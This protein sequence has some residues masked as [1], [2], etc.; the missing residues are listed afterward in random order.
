MRSVILALS[1]STLLC[2]S[3]A[4]SQSR[5][6]I[7]PQRIC[8]NN[9][10]GAI[11]TKSKCSASETTLSGQVLQELRGVSVGPKGD[12]GDSGLSG[13]VDPNKCY[14]RESSSVGSGY[15]AVSSACLVS[16]MLL[17]SGCHANNVGVVVGQKLWKGSGSLVSN[18]DLYGGVECQATAGSSFTL[19]AQALCCRP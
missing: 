13:T 2:V 1:F 12:K 3:P 14:R 10:S 8:M 17:A 16:E 11:L 15:V 18:P 5:T 19:T 9:A 4:L 7:A 6:R